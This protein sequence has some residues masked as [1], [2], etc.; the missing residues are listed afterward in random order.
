MGR[1][2]PS[3]GRGNGRPSTHPHRAYGCGLNS[4]SFSPD[5]G[6]LASGSGYGDETIRLWDAA[7]GAHL[8]TLTGHTGP[9][10]NSVSFSPDGGT[11][12][13]GSWDDTIRLWDAATG[14]HIRTLT[15]HTDPVN[16]VSF[17]P[18][19]GTIASGSAEYYGRDYPS[20][21]RGNGRPSTH[22]H[23]A[24]GLRSRAYHSVPME[25][26]SQVGVGTRLSVYGTR[27]RAPIYAPS[28]GI[29]V[30][31]IA[32]HSVPMEG[33]SQVGAGIWTLLS[34]Y[35][36]RQRAPIY[37]PSPGIRMVY[38]VSFSPDGGTIAS[39]SLDDTIRLWDA[40]TG[41]HRRP[42]LT[43]H[44]GWV[45]S[46]SFSPDGGT[47]ASGSGDRTIRLWDAATGA[48]LRTLTGHTGVV[49]SV[50][51]SPDGGTI[52]SGSWGR[53]PSLGR[54]NGRPS[55]HPHRAYGLCL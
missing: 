52:A 53:N 16:S 43:G 4:V 41:A 25:G 47:I 14:A 38:S 6:T 46:V 39:G 1:Y 15:G 35:G 2:Y 19:G 18:D 50:S 23:R 33:L 42:T 55:T 40:A 29:R 36:T 31:S 30:G 44:T 8:R 49:N 13:S 11:I 24:Y 45:F 54:G 37:A 5:G 51:F 34:V 17:S 48:H 22:P 21:G 10:L 9:V 28:P 26:L 32:Y 7:T 20:M 27:Q 3:M 12:A